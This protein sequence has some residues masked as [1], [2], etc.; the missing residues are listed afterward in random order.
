MGDGGGQW[1]PI[2]FSNGFKVTKLLWVLEAHSAFAS[3]TVFASESEQWMPKFDQ[4]LEFL[5]QSC[6]HFGDLTN[7]WIPATKLRGGAYIFLFLRLLPKGAQIMK[8]CVIGTGYVGLVAGA[9][10]AD[11]GNDVNCVDQ[12]KTK[13]EKLNRG[14]IPIYEPGLDALVERNA[15]K[16]RIRFST[17]LASSVK[18]VAVVFMAVGTPQGEDGNADLSALYAAAQQVAEANDG[19]TVT[20]TRAR[21]PGKCGP[22]HEFST[23]HAKYEALVVSNPNSHGRRCHQRFHAA[24]ARI[25]G[26][27]TSGPEASCTSSISRSCARGAHHRHGHSQRRLTKNATNA[28][29]HAHFVMNNIARLFEIVG[30]DVEQVRKGMGSDTRNAPSFTIPEQ[31]TGVPFSPP[32]Y[33]RSS[34][35]FPPD[36]L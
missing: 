5:L 12:D 23:G 10:F 15:K 16:G 4:N 2:E 19:F 18:G 13:I 21:F 8:I 35:S 22:C 6:L 17:D 27:P 32:R 1:G 33:H 34:L 9:A 26:T 30:A 29:L 25:I 20:W 36:G 11:F 28:F 14:I 3:V 7:V 31:D 24:R